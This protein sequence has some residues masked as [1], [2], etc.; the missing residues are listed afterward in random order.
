MTSRWLSSAHRWF[1]GRM[2]ACHAGGPGSIPGRCK[3]SPFYTDNEARERM[4]TFS[5]HSEQ[6]L[7]ISSR[8]IYHYGLGLKVHQPGVEP[9]STAW[10][11]TML[12]VTPLMPHG[13]FKMRSCSA[14]QGLYR[15]TSFF[16]QMYSSGNLVSFNGNT[17]G[18]RGGGNYA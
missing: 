3:F 5:P 14:S 2:L 17:N 4:A 11:A 1:S 13:T 12:T 10:K 15:G 8:H 9:G 7:T 16:Q 18:W 6:L